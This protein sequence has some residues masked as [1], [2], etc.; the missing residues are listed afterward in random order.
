L[1][2]KKLYLCKSK[3]K[4]KMSIDKKKKEE[5]IIPVDTFVERIENFFV[6]Y[7]KQINI[8]SSVVLVVIAVIVAFFVWYLPKQEAKAELAIYK[9][10]QYFAQDSFALALKGN[11]MYD[12]LLTIIDEYG[13]TK[14][15]NRAKYLAGICYLKTGKFDDAITYLKKFRGKDKLV[16]VQALASI[17]DAYVEK[18]DYKNGLKYYQKAVDKNPNEVITPM[19]LMRAAMLCEMNNQWEDAL[20]F[21]ERVQKE[22]PTSNESQDIEKRI[23]FVKVKMG[24]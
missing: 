3:N 23:E 11:G 18:N 14:T 8:I 19:Y 20:T 7:K 6:T 1:K 5:V 21:Y 16:S 15:G 12:G 17:G 24:K 9:A 10:E 22:Y 4:I 13:I 2:I